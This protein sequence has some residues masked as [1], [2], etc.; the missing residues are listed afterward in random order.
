M[1]DLS[2]VFPIPRVVFLPKT[3]LGYGLLGLPWNPCGF[4]VRNTQVFHLQAS[5]NKK[6]ISPAVA[7]T[8]FNILILAKR[9]MHW[10]IKG[11]TMG[12]FVT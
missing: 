5:C 2:P 11:A 6:P 4:K 9:P 1:A 7:Y 12:M 8:T 3:S 10:Q